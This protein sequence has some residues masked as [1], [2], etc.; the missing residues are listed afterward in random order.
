VRINCYLKPIVMIARNTG[1][2]KGEI[3]ALKWPDV[4][5]K[6]NVVTVRG[7]T[8]KSK[9]TR[10][11]PLNSVAIDVFK[12]WYDQTEDDDLFP[13]ASFKTA[14]N[15]VIK[16]AKIKDFTFHDLRHDFASRLVMSG[17][18]LKT[19]QELLGHADL[20]MTLRYSHLAPSHKVSAVERLV[21]NEL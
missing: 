16:D 15:A 6:S 21:G 13:I 1:M 4:D 2:R 10:H 12:K 7:V 8:A 17:V 9:R 3:L 14:W 20:T 18:D 11:L 19:I 5:F